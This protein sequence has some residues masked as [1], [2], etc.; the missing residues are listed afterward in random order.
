MAVH[1]VPKKNWT[2][3]I[4]SCNFT[5]T[6]LLSIILGMKNLQFILN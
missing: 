5:S 1:R 3:V 4:F 6:A 2:Q